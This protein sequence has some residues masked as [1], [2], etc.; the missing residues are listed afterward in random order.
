MLGFAAL[1]RL[2]LG[3]ITEEE[4]QEEESFDHGY[5]PFTRERRILFVGRAPVRTVVRS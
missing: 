5:R 3:E 2:G 1:G 4:A